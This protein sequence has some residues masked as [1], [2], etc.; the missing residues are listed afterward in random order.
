MEKAFN[1]IFDSTLDLLQAN[2]NAARSGEAVQP[3][4]GIGSVPFSGQLD[5]N[6]NYSYSCSKY[7]GGITV[8]FTAAI[9]APPGSYDIHISSTDGGAYDFN[10]VQVNQAI[11]GQLHT[12]FLHS[13]N[14]NVSVRSN[15]VRNTTVNGTLN[16]SY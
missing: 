6:G 13:S 4:D 16:Y 3:A 14:I 9:S 10:N 15:T 5:G 8:N 7:G 1:K 2:I 12:S 11:S